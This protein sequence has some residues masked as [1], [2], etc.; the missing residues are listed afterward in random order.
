MVDNYHQ[1]GHIVNFILRHSCA[2]TLARKFNLTTRAAAFRKFGF[3]LT[4]NFKKNNK[5]KSYSLAIPNNFR[6][7]KVF[8]IGQ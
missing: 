6:K 5:P 1:F 4:V 2:K 3:Y 8:K 7:K